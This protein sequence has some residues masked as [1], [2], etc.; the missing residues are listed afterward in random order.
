MYV[1]KKPKQLLYYLVF[2]NKEMIIV[3]K[4]HD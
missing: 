1:L 2:V 3:V 4:L